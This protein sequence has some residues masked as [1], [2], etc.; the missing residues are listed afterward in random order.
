MRQ[1]FGLAPLLWFFAFGTHAQVP[2]NPIGLNPPSLNWQEINTDR[3]QVI[4]PAE[5]EPQAQRLASIVHYMWD[6]NNQTIGDSM[7][8][9]SIML[10]NQPVV[11]NGF[12]TVG[13]FRSEFYASPPQ[14]NMLSNWIDILAIHEYRHVMQFG[15]SRKGI[16][17]LAR[18]TLGSWAWGG[19]VG[20]ALPRWFFEGDAVAMETA[21]TGSG[22][23]RLPAFSMEYRALLADDI[24]YDYEKAAAGSLM[25]YVPNWYTLGYYLTTYA[26]KQFGAGVWGPVVDDAVRYRKLF[27][28]FSQSLEKH[29]G[30][31]T[32]ELY[33]ATYTFLDSLWSDQPAGRLGPG[34]TWNRR[35]SPTVV[36]YNLPLDL[37]DGRI[38][39][40]KR[41]YDQIPTFVAIDSIGTEE[42]IT[43]PGLVFSPLNTTLSLAGNT[44][45][46][47]ELGFDLRWGNRTFSVIRTYDMVTN[48]K[49]RI[50]SK[51][52]LYS[53][54][55]DQRAERIAAIDLGQD[56]SMQVV[57]LDATSGTLIDRLPNPEGSF[58]AFPR[59]MPDET[60]IVVV[61]QNDERS[62]LL[63]VEL[64]TG[65][66]RDLTP[67]EAYHL[68]HPFPHG[69]YVY[70]SGAYQGANNIFA[71]HVSSQRIYQ[72]T[73]VFTGAFQPSVSQDGR[74]LF[75]SLFTS[76]GYD[77]RRLPLE[78]AL[79][80]EI[81][82]ESDYA[83]SLAS[84]LDEQE[85]GSI[86]GDLPRG[87]FEVDRFNPYRKLIFPHS[88]LPV[89]SPPVIGLELLSDNIFGTLSASAGIFYNANERE[90][91]LT[92]GGRYAALFPVLD[93]NYRLSHRSAF[94][95]NYQ[96][97]DDTTLVQ[98]AYNEDWVEHYAAGA[99][100]VP[101]N[102]SAGNV[103]TRLNLGAELGYLHVRPEGT[104]DQPGLPRDTIAVG[105]VNA[106]DPILRPP[107]DRGSTASIDL[108]ADFRSFRRMALQHLNPRWGLRLG[109]RLRRT[110]G[111][112]SLSGS[113]WTSYAD[114]YLPALHPN[115]STFLNI[116]Y[117]EEDLLNN[118]HYPDIFFYPRGYRSQLQDRFIKLG[119]NYSM[120]LAYPDLALGPVA[121]LKRVKTN[122][123]FDWG[124]AY[125]DFPFNTREDISSAGIELTA[126]F[127]LFRLLEVDAGIRYSYAFQADATSNGSH[128]QFDFV[129]FSIR[130]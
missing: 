20:A 24:H 48:E 79:W 55:L 43:S 51:T 28:P 98:T 75:F 84:M 15:N 49:R 120:P 105:D 101:L 90:I 27:F 60:A 3:V 77:L 17:N 85:G 108:R 78:A 76:R 16:T 36:N 12:V 18:Q 96:A 26:R 30:L 112:T 39:V 69:E 94:L 100:S 58:L 47:S 67:P 73:D 2:A 53:P 40:Q 122:V 33:Q 50:T 1:L 124:R 104:F 9:V 56:M 14:F 4:F 89:G 72:L 46:W 119:V 5:M 80:R 95:L 61:A 10:H 74:Y 106:L 107:I 113:Q 41:G 109:T 65:K 37:G 59:W 88:L 21:L 54:A 31:T 130:E 99:V 6:N 103:V 22:R 29:T 62:R 102:F 70:F 127:R 44:L 82:T 35:S 110:L 129:L 8:P 114:L 25:D 52:R 11:S 81:V 116:A 91:S 125:L 38:V 117:M 45:A 66:T 19:F 121:F 42:K 118:Y 111:G 128:H 64:A 32:P 92:A 63:T 87:E 126:D 86:V 115:H 34:K 123:F 97:I 83:D 71:V 7:I 13:P 93:A 68:S 57:I 23:G